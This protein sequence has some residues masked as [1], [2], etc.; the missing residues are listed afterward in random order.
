MR[1]I[2]G[3]GN[4]GSRYARTRHNAGFDAVELLAARHGIELR[5]LQCKAKLGEGRIRGERV[6]IAQPQT[7]MNLS[8]ES[9]ARLV[10]WYKIELNRL[11]VCYDDVD[12]PPGVLRVRA[13]GSAGTHNGMRSILYHLQSEDF[14]RVRIGIGG[15][16]DEWDLKDFVTSRYE[17]PE[18]RSVAF[19]GYLRAADLIEVVVS[20][21]VEAAARIAGEYARARR[22]SAGG[23]DER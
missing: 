12:L 11:I 18:Q 5:K 4:P 10:Q 21:G 23:E 17:T 9:V 15:A 22:E 6:A 8:G 16:P 7:Y 13:R 1:L 3:L 2:V 20:E 14:A 19:E